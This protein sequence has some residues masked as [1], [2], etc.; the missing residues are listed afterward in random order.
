MAADRPTQ[1]KPRLAHPGHAQRRAIRS[2]RLYSLEFGTERRLR[3]RRPG[4]R[5]PPSALHENGPLR[6]CNGPFSAPNAAPASPAATPQATERR[7]HRSRHV[8]RGRVEGYR[9]GHQGARD[10]VEDQRLDEGMAIAD[11][12]LRANS[13]AN[14]A[15]G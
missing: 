2:V 3:I 14:L 8:E 4:V 12:T 6:P 10:E 9:L 13:G 7:P 11:P 5:I 15:C 1:V